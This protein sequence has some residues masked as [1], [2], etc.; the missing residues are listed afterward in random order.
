M[1]FLQ[2]KARTLL[3]NKIFL[4]PPYYLLKYLEK[5]EQKATEIEIKQ[6]YHIDESF[7]LGPKSSIYGNGE[8][9][10]RSNSYIQTKC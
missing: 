2:K 7:T 9:T 5:I 1:N 3:K 6:K 10:I 4:Y 8:I